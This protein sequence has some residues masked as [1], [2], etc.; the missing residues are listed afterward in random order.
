MASVLHGNERFDV[1]PGFNNQAVRDNETGLV[2]ERTPETI[3]RTWEDAVRTCWIRQIGGPH[4]FRHP[5]DDRGIS[6]FGGSDD[7]S[8]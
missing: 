3:P 5:P 6:K 4:G 8:S 2:W 7:S 1:L